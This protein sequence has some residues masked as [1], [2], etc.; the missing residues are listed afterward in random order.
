MKL[1]RRRGFYSEIAVNSIKSMVEDIVWTK[2]FILI[3]YKDQ[4]SGI[5]SLMFFKPIAC[6][7][8]NDKTTRHRNNQ[9]D[10]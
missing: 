1:N 10:R 7:V 3:F 8:Q 5:S 4:W 2:P 6:F 9:L